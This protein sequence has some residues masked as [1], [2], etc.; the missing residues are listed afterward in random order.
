MQEYEDIEP[1]IEQIKAGGQNLL[2]RDKVLLLE[3][4][5]GSSGVSKLIPY[6]QGLKREFQSGISAWIADIFL[7]MPSLLTGRSYWSISPPTK[8]DFGKSAVKIGFDDDS[9]YLGRIARLVA[10]QMKPRSMMAAGRIS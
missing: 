4:T 9:Q 6:T 7:A 10:R 8:R 5:S 1:Y 3:P 2:T